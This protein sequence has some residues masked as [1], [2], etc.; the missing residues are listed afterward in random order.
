MNVAGIL[1]VTSIA[2][3]PTMVEALSALP[4]VEVHHVDKTTGRIIATQEA[5]SIHDEIDA[6]TVIKALPHVVL[7]EMVHHHFEDDRQII[8]AIPSELD[9]ERLTRVPPMLDG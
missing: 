9:D 2:K 7:A 1:V 3:V 6:I 5:E 8:D 4:G